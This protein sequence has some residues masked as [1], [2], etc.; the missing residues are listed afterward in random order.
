M[1]YVLQR[2]RNLIKRVAGSFIRSALIVTVLAT[3]RVSMAAEASNPPLVIGPGTEALL[4]YTLVD[5]KGVEI[6]TNKGKSPLTY[7]PGSNEVPPG[8]EKAL[9]GL[10]AGQEKVV[11]LSP[12]EGYGTVR[13][14]ALQEVPKDAI[15]AESRMVGAILRAQS[16]S[17]TKTVRISEIRNKTII[18]DF[19]H[20]YAGKTLVYHV[21][22]LDV[23][24]AMEKPPISSAG[25]DGS[26][27]AVDNAD[28]AKKSFK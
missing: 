25:S 2:G 21:K 7:L 14:D 6:E 20:P 5:D 8:L 10:R 4:E 9:V 28:P 11:K 22:V 1:A 24:T 26:G 15:P 27:S 18:V 16:G 3:A 23:R 12:E 19:N 17:Q 13:K